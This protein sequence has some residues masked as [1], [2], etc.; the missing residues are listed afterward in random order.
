G[1]RILRAVVLSAARLQRVPVILL[2]ERK[3]LGRFQHRYGPN[4]VGP[5]GVLQPMAETGKLIFQEQFRPTNSI[6]WLFAIAPAI[7]MMTAVAGVA[8]IPFSNT[9]DIFG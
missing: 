4:R 2:V 5:F 8:V 3:L 1:S 7:S 6:G 9:V